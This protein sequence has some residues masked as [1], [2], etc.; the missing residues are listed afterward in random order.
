MLLRS[1]MAEN[2]AR[3]GG[4]SDQR[5]GLA[6]LQPAGLSQ[7][8]R[9]GFGNQIKHLAANH[10]RRSRRHR[11]RRHQRRAHRRLRVSRG[12]RQHFKGQGQ[13]PVAGQNGHRLV[14]LFMNRRP[15]PAQVAVVHG[16]Q[17]IMNQR[18]AMN[19]LHRHPGSQGVLGRHVKQTRTLQDQE[20]AQSLASSQCAIPHGIP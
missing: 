3:F 15:S 6:L 17:V 7:I 13:Q 12:V 1:G 2:R 18:V 16:W 5:P 11:Q 9:R 8:K 20:G 10:A 4:E 19:Q 14:E